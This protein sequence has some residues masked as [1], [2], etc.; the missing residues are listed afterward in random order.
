MRSQIRKTAASIVSG[1]GY[2]VLVSYSTPVAAILPDGSYVRTSSWYS[3]TTT[4]HI[5]EFLK[6]SKGEVKEV[7]PDELKEILDKVE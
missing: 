3:V 4:R 5:N 1:M 7:S 6:G 2:T